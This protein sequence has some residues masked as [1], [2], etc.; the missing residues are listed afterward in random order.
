MRRLPI[1]VFTALLLV[2]AGSLAAGEVALAPFVGYS[3]GPSVQETQTGH[4][5]S[6]IRILG[7]ECDDHRGLFR[8]Q[9]SIYEFLNPVV[10]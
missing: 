8:R 3:T 1:A 6:Q 2:I 4:S 5:A 9:P 10:R 7:E